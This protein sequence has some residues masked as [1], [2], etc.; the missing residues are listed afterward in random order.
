VGPCSGSGSS[1]RLQSET[2]ATAS[3]SSLSTR[4]TRTSCASS[5]SSVAV[6]ATAPRRGPRS[7]RADGEPGLSPACPWS[8]SPPISIE[9]IRLPQGLDRPPC[10]LDHQLLAEPS[11]LGVGVE[12]KRAGGPDALTER[13]GA[14]A[15]LGP[16][17][18]APAST[19]RP[20]ETRSVPSMRV[21]SWRPLPGSRAFPE[22]PQTIA[23]REVR[24]SDTR[25]IR[26]WAR[27][28]DVP[29]GR[30]A[31]ACVQGQEEPAHSARVAHLRIR[32][33]PK[34]G[35]VPLSGSAREGHDDS[36]SR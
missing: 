34:S 28:L 13:V 27:H 32:L 2:T 15:V 30:P 6:Q 4:A 24:R 26:R 12:G 1:G 8:E 17:D 3:P 35:S 20:V 19:G 36:S 5:S 18:P 23:T 25:G 16:V 21:A 9:R 33:I 31:A 11:E 29:D 7:R 14:L 10:R 22:H